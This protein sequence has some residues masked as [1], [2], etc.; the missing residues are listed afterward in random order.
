MSI[1]RQAGVK[2]FHGPMA[3]FVT[4]PC[5]SLLLSNGCAGDG[6]VGATPL[7]WG[8]PVTSREERLWSR[9][10]MDSVPRWTVAEEP[11][12]VVARDSQGADPQREFDE[13]AIL[14]DGRVAVFFGPDSSRHESILL[15][16]VDPSSGERLLVSAP[17][18]EDGESLNWSHFGM[19]AHQGGFVLS[20]NNMSDY[21]TG[22][23]DIWYLDREGQLVRPPFTAPSGGVLGLFPDGSLVVAGT[24]EAG[25]VDTRLVSAIMSVPAA[26]A[27]NEPM[28]AH[29]PEL[30]FLTAIPRDPTLP[31][32]YNY[33]A[34]FAHF[35]WHTSGVAGDT[36]WIVPTER[37]E[38][39]AVD[40]SG[41]VVL[42]VQWEAGD[43]TIP[44]EAPAFGRGVERYPAARRLRIG[45]DGLIYVQG[46]VLRDG[47]VDFSAE[48]LVFS[49]VGELLARLDVP[50]SQQA[51]AFG[52]GVV[53]TT[54]QNEV[55]GANEVRYYEL[56][57]TPWVKGGPRLPRPNAA[58]SP[59]PG[60][61]LIG[62][63]VTFSHALGHAVCKV[64]GRESLGDTNHHSFPLTPKSRRLAVLPSEELRHLLDRPEPAPEQHRHEGDAFFGREALKIDGS[65]PF[66]VGG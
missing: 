20:G 5:A 58:R 10:S 56:T 33:P 13:A 61:M 54:G 16:I 52:D 22:Y 32:K 35:P 29:E 25:S 36:I 7:G 18:G 62:L 66:L 8:G 6:S 19:V 59:I 9:A 40:R 27:G 15:Q 2:R 42:K 44:P 17:T 38:L 24:I 45:T 43:R 14:A 47:H 23:Q 49:P 50:G 3:V 51:L 12:F 28:S 64:G 31:Y 30:L 37:P 1:G 34:R 48:W 53:V 4:I 55:S 26:A 11:S 63:D 39:L 60:P 21:E 46:F 65:S 57:T 41:E